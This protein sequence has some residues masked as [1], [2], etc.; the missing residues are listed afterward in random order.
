[1]C[2]PIFAKGYPFRYDSEDAAKARELLLEL[3]QPE[4]QVNFLISMCAISLQEQGLFIQS[5]RL[6]DELLKSGSLSALEK[7]VILENNAVVC[8][9][10]KKFKLMIGYMKKALV[11]YERSGNVY[12]VAV[13][14]KNIGEAEWQ[15]GFKEAAWNY[16]RKSEKK[17]SSLTE[18][19][20]RFGVLWNLASAFRGVRERKAEQEYLTKCLAALPDSEI[21]KIILIEQRLQQL[22]KFSF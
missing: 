1:V 15:M 19:M 18:P 4:Q 12:R 6:N 16:F 8:R 7:G 14:L 3:L 5:I 13:G 22:D 10:N 17:M 11:E 2:S 9:N 21:E 20:E